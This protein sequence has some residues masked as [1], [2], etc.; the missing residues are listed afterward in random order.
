[1][2]GFGTGLGF[3]G[4]AGS[5]SGQVSQ[6]SGPYDPLTIT[7]NG[8][9]VAFTDEESPEE[10]ETAL[11]R[12]QSITTYIGGTRIAQDMGP[13]PNPI[14]IKGQLFAGNVA[15]RVGQLFALWG[16]GQTCTLSYL[17]NKYSILIKSFK[18]K[19]LHRWRCEYEL[20]VSILADLAGQ[21]NQTPP[22]GV[23]QQVD[24][25][26]QQ[27]ADYVNGLIAKDAGGTVA[28]NAAFTLL[29]ATLEAIGLIQ[30]LASGDLQQLVNYA[31]AAA[32][33]AGTYA[34]SIGGANGNSAQYLLAL[35]A[36]TGAQLISKNLQKG[37]A[38]TVI[39]VNGGTTP[40]LFALAS[41][42]TASTG[43]I[44]YFA[45]SIAAANGLT[46]PLLSAS[47]VYDLR[48]PP[49]PTSTAA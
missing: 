27:T 44:P 2:G 12:M 22:Q 9:T 19:W 20:I 31:D 21:Y 10:F 36:Q 23:D 40:D 32:L 8:V 3:G 18:P 47:Q 48:I 29:F 5:G 33:S 16:A 42:L 11:K 45:F 13:D 24:M 28:L 26:S 17:T 14:T 38:P 49:I 35:Q 37:S 34:Q 30:D 15:L 7:G 4:S 25:I 41:S 6:T 1:M 46:S 39:R 43:G